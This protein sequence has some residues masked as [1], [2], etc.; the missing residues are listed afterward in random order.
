MPPAA[1][2]RAPGTPR[3][4]AQAPAFDAIE[5]HGAIWIKRAGAVAAFPDLRCQ[6]YSPICVLRHLVRA[7][8]EPLL[9]N[10]IEVEHTPTT[11]AF[12]GYPLEAM[13]EVETRVEVSEAAVRVWNK[14]PQ[15][16]LPW[17]VSQLLG[18]RTGD[19]FIDDWTTY[20]SPVFTLY[21]HY[22]LDRDTGE[23][24]P[25]RLRTAVFFNPITAG[26]TELFTFV[27][28]SA[29]P[30]G[31]RGLN[32]VIRPLIAAL[33]DREVRL[34]RDMVEGLADQNPSHRGLKLGRFDRPLLETR[35]RI[36][37]LYRGQVSRPAD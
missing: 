24:H 10:F 32:R 26:E 19:P 16:P 21:D 8:L 17:I 35:R 31:R 1:R 23:P 6:G 20:F 14:G 27:F 2:E 15:K 30:W 22:W 28:A 37:K 5:R 11:H 13:S 34:D 18:I 25:E 29:S 4:E 12:F 7:P 9:D 3:L 33:V 36:D